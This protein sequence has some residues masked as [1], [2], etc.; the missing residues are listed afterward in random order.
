VN[1]AAVTGIIITIIVGVTIT[2]ITAITA[3]VEACPA[4]RE[5]EIPDI[6]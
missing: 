6:E 1:R 3:A 5:R 2:I 4:R